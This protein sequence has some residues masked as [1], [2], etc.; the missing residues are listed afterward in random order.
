MLKASGFDWDSGNAFKSEEKHGISKEAVE[1]FF[2]SQVWVSPDP[3][4]S[5]KEAR[6]LAIGSGPERRPMFVVFTFRH[7]DGVRL[8]RPISARFMHL[9]E[10]LRYEKKFTKNEK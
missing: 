4:H 1:S 9:K 8:I 5:Q 6:F 3:K 10:I 7:R 2:H